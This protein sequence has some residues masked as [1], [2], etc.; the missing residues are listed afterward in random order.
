MKCQ[1]DWG[2]IIYHA[3]VVKA[4]NKVGYE[5]QVLHLMGRHK[6]TLEYKVFH[7]DPGKLVKLD[8]TKPK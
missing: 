4:T 5:Q 7:G 3:R 1:S 6:K 8:Q 2:G